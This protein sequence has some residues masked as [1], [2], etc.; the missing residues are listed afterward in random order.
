MAR[1]KL[2]ATQGDTEERLLIAAESEF[3]RVGI[4]KARLEDIAKSVGISRSS[5]LYHFESKDALYKEVVRRTISKL[6]QALNQALNI[7]CRFTKRLELSIQNYT[8][9]LETHPN[10]ALILLREFI[11]GSGP[12]HAFL[13]KELVPLFD[14]MET[15]IRT[16]GSRFI[17]RNYPVR[18]AILQIVFTSLIY[19]AVGKLR[20]PL[21][22][23]RREQ[24]RILLRKLFF[25]QNK[26]NTHSY[27]SIRS[28]KK[29]SPYV[30]TSS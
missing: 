26:S 1:P 8:N 12:R 27:L 2:T 25:P 20:E 18:E 17:K 13:L 30:P 6:K 24:P 7:Q 5:L 11:D 23:Q 19:S 21:W 22:G 10:L 16:Q 4:D 15:F 3:A 29:E 9:F 28:V 14:M